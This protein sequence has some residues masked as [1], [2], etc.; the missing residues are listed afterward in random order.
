MKNDQVSRPARRISAKTLSSAEVFG[1]GAALGLT[2]VA[3]SGSAVVAAVRRR[4]REMEV[5]PGELA[6]QKW[7]Q[8]KAAAQAGAAGWRNGSQPPHEG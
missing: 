5:P 4:M 7:A 2:G 8:T 6:R 1:I 3:L